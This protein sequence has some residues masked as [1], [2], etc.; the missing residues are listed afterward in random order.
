MAQFDLIAMH[1]TWSWISAG[2]RHLVV[3]ILR[4]LL[5]PG[6]V[7]LISYNCLP[8]WAGELPLRRLLN[9]FSAGGDAGA[10]AR[11]LERLR[12]CGF[13]YFKTNSV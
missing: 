4:R 2:N 12:A 11:E 6:G 1:G 10:A 8:G 13:A 7:C 5:A 9:E 3:E